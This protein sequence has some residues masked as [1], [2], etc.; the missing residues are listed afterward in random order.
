MAWAA[1]AKVAISAA[2]DKRF[3][4]IL[5]SIISVVIALLFLITACCT[6]A[7]EAVSTA[8]L[9]LIDSA[10]NISSTPENT[11]EITKQTLE[12]YRNKN[13]SIE[14]T[15]STLCPGI[16]TLRIQSAYFILRENGT[17]TEDISEEDLIDCFVT[18][19]EN[20]DGETYYIPVESDEKVYGNI[21][22]KFS[23]AI[24]E[25][26][27]K[28]VGEL[29]KY[30]LTKLGPRENSGG[31]G[32][33][34]DLLKNDDSPY[35]GGSFSSP[36]PSINWKSHV[37]SEYGYRIHPISGVRKLH[38]GIDIAAGKGTAIHAVQSGKVLFVRY[39]DTGKGYHVVLNHGGKIT[40][41]YA[42]CSKIV[43][44]AG[45]IITKGQIIAYVGST[46]DSTGPHLHF[47]VSKNGETQ[48][49]RNWLP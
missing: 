1:V 13:L 20:L 34:A 24:D 15:S 32:R 7:C 40:T 17:F 23:V 4:K 33:I 18:Q 27:R 44:T 38:S 43:V 49:P 26:S 48:N 19:I 47:E 37:T 10:F 16:D 5:G 42:H 9:S 29:Y 22:D 11:D 31:S 39:Y 45:D 21:E 28:N 6:A 30:L 2:K 14:S 12:Q 46:G 25:T 8:G 36:L 35:I 41:T 3:W